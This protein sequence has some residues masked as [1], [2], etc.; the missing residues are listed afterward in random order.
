M[1]PFIQVPGAVLAVL[2]GMSALAAKP[3]DAKP[4]APKDIATATHDMQH[5]AGFFDVHRDTARARVLLGLSEFNQPFLLISSLPWAIG[6]N[7][8]GL[9]RGQSSGSH[10]VEFRRAGQRV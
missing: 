9:D 1:R 8:I 5:V 3:D 4:P 7:D 2:L 6:S 10:L